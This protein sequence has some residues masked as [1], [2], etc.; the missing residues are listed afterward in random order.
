[1]RDVLYHTMFGHSLWLGRWQRRPAAS[2]PP[3]DAFSNLAKLRS[4]WRPIEDESAAFVATLAGADLAA[5]VSFTSSSGLPFSHP[6]WVLL[7]TQVTHATQHR[8]E[9]AL[10]LTD[11]GHSPGDLDFVVYRTTASARR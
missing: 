3:A 11:L 9:V 7:L 10:T 4:R 5:D 6:L 2:F 1:M 8:S